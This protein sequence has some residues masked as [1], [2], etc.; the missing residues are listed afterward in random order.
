MNVVIVGTERYLWISTNWVAR[1]TPCDPA[2]TAVRERKRM[3]PPPKGWMGEAALEWG[4]GVGEKVKHIAPIPLPE[5][6][7]AEDF[8]G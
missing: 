8:H 6:F 7:M 2:A 5:R 1:Q 4:G 3:P